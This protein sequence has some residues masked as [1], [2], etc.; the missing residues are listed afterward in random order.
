MKKSANISIGRDANG[1]EININVDE[2]N[3]A[4]KQQIE[5]LLQA[6]RDE[7]KSQIKSELTDE[8][9]KQCKEQDSQIKKSDEKIEG[10]KTQ[11]DN[12]Q[13][14]GIDEKIN[15]SQG[16]LKDDINPK[17]SSLRKWQSVIK[18]FLAAAVVLGVIALCVSLCAFS[19]DS[20]AFLGWTIAVLSMIVVVLMGW[21]IFSILD[22]KEYRVALSKTDSL[23]KDIRQF[24][25]Q[26][27][28][29]KNG[30]TTE[31]DVLKNKIKDL[32]QKYEQL[33]TELLPD[34][35]EAKGLAYEN[36]DM[37]K[38]IEC[39]LEA[40]EIVVDELDRAQASSTINRVQ[41][42][43]A[44]DRIYWLW[45]NKKNKD[46]VR[47]MFKSSPTVTRKMEKIKNN[48]SHTLIRGFEIFYERVN[49]YKTEN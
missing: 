48:T 30:D 6:R 44:I 35:Y 42:S 16:Q 45:E 12:L 28:E 47:R 31:K 24:K 23:E 49:K 15:S 21:H 17:I 32:E 46:N 4:V 9:E 36:I 18:I 11:V 34:I 27:S 33:N 13:N 38:S 19:I 22:L 2:F 3:N 29:I 5:I 1:T 39:Y 26:L 41:V 20:M 37:E 25:V 8:I 40:V 7:L 10:L 43:S 14:Q